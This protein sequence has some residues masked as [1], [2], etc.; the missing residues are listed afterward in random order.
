[1]RLSLA[2]TLAA[3]AFTAFVQG[4]SASDSLPDDGAAGQRAADPFETPENLEFTKESVNVDKAFSDSVVVAED[5]LVVPTS[6]NAAMLAKIAVGSIVAGDRTSKVASPDELLATNNPYGFLRKVK[7]IHTDGANTV[8]MTDKAELA[9]WIEEGDL[10]YDDAARSVFEP[11]AG[12]PVVN[13][14]QKNIKIQGGKSEGGASGSGTASLDNA[15]EGGVITAAD[16]KVKPLVKVTNGSFKLNA[17]FDG[18]FKVRKHW[19]IPTSVKFRS[20]LALDPVVAADIEAGVILA[21][22]SL[23]NGQ[24]GVG[25]KIGVPLWEKSIKGKDIVIPMGGPIP[26]T[27]RFAPE[28]KCSVSATGTVT[29]KVHAE[30]GLHTAV[31]FEGKAGFSGFDWNDISEAP[32]I[33]PSLKLLGVQEKATM[34]AECELLAVPVLLA[35]DTVGLQGKVGPYVSLNAALCET[36]TPK[37]GVSV[38]FSLFE[39]HGLAGEFGGRVQVPFLGKGKDFSLISLRALKSDEHY[40]VGD[41]QSCEIPTVDSCKGRQDGFY[42][43]ELNDY[44]GFYCEGE[45][46]AIG[47]QCSETQKCTGGTRDDIKCQ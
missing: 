31:G 32:S 30:V 4:C 1:M 9:D 7:E 27:L 46:I 44:S 8:L 14:N 24:V 38:D 29:A 21:A 6:T 12:G 18:Y 26:I 11:V 20:H 15:L 13:T 36:A 28:L 45:Q 5:R 47:H 42:C 43:S 34:T 25:T 3:V 41:A 39:Q 23:K 2:A 35:F 19:K 10:F 16:V 33:T 17:N 37:Q 40:L 22:G